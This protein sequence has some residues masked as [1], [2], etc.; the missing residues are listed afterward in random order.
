MLFWT[1]IALMTAAAVLAVLWPLSREPRAAGE[2]AGLAVYRDQLAEIE[3][4]RARGTLPASE[5]EA[6]RIEVSRR[7][8][9][10]ASRKTPTADTSLANRRIASLV[11]LFGIPVFS[12]SLYLYLGAPEFPDAPFVARTALPVEQQDIGMLIG[13]LEERLEQ[14]PDH[15][16]GWELIAPIYMRAGR[17][18][19]AVAAQE[20]AIRILGGTAAREVALGE[21]LRIANGR[22][23]AEAKAAFERAL[24]LDQKSSAALFY[25]G[26]E[27]EESGRPADAK[28][29]WSQLTGNA[30]ENDP[31]RIPAQRRLMLIEKKQ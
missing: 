13:R 27:A 3:S 7:L 18:G 9:G 12:L 28:K 4:D 23:A 21:Y 24:I 26:L 1:L 29:F 16:Q 5:A 15:G 17:S 14:N 20:K 25:L 8:L 11:A 19:D 22:I 6:A 30:I 10:A 31:W 2:A